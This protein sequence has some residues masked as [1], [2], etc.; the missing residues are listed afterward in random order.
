ME[1]E[2][3]KDRFRSGK[4]TIDANVIIYYCVRT[5]E[6][7]NNVFSGVPRSERV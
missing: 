3:D 2:G 1:I 4:E 7:T 6:K 5:D